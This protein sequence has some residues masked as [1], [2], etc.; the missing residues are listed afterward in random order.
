MENFKINIFNALEVK[1][2]ILVGV[3]MVAY[4]LSP[5][6]TTKLLQITAE[7]LFSLIKDGF[8]ASIGRLENKTIW[9]MLDILGLSLSCSVFS[10]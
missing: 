1:T 2:W 9:F 4:N 7:T 3:Y 8:V 5:I 10:V 6:K